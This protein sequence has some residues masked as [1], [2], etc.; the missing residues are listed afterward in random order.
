MSERA[1]KLLKVIEKVSW[2]WESMQQSH[3]S[4]IAAAVIREIVDNCEYF[5]DDDSFGS[6][7][8][9]SKDLID[10]AN[11]LENLK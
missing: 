1:Q 7:V 2:D 10:L 5:H 11:E 3:P 6:M 8:I 4:T 9:N